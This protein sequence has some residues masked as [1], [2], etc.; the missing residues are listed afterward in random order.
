M[1]N[2]K[3]VV[4]RED[5]I[6]QRRNAREIAFKLVFE[7]T[8]NNEENRDMLEE[9]IE[10][11]LPDNVSYINEVYFGVISHYDELIEHIKTNTQNFALDRIFKVDLAL[12]LLALYE[13]IYMEKI[14]YKVSVDEAL[15]LAEKY[16]TEKS[17]NYIN[18]VLAK[19]SR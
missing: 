6:K 15:T 2:N 19:F 10:G 8:F 14:P 12:L 7:Y 9:H 11:V 16:S 1:D 5:K 4:S 3:N 17:S 13:I 18:G